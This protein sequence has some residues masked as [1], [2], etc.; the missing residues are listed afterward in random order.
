MP[1]EITGKTKLDDDAVLYQKREEKDERQKWEKLDR[2]GKWQY[3]KDYYLLKVVLLLVVLAILG[4]VVYTM[5]K[6]RPEIILNVVVINQTM[7]EGQR[8]AFLTDLSNFLKID[9]KEQ[10][11][12]LE[13]NYRL[14][15]EKVDEMTMASQT[16]MMANASA[17][18]LDV[19]IADR[20]TFEHYMEQGMFVDLSQILPE[21]LYRRLEDQMAEGCVLPRTDAEPDLTESDGAE[22]TEAE[23]GEEN[24]M[25][26][27][28]PYGV[29]LEQAENY[30]KDGTYG[31]T[32]YF[33]IAG[34][35]DHTEEAVRMLRYLFE[36]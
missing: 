24:G 12:Q 30:P 28:L 20:Q 31:E 16:K 10:K 4:S 21:D 33:A 9:E 18:E 13:D 2:K 1:K 3:F 5:V 26:E 7:E 8:E 23:T 34:V 22:I 27:L 32:M 35:G 17:G 25:T 29:A 36:S 15:M 19:V 6:P 11:I 14:D